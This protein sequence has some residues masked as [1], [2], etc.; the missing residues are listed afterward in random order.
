MIDKKPTRRYYCIIEDKGCDR[1]SVRKKRNIII[2]I[3]AC[4]L[5][6]MAV[7]YALLR[8]NLNISSTGTLTGVWKIYISDM[9]VKNTNGKATEVTHSFNAT[10]ANFEVDLYMP[11]DYVEYYITVT[12]D[13]NIDATLNQIIV[14]ATNSHED[15]KLSHT[16]EEG[17]VLNGGES[18][19]Y[20][21]KIEFDKNATKIP[22]IEEP[23]KYEIMLIYKT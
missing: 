14:N 17:E 18:K 3:L 23:V 11:G 6:L 8:Q 12:N 4:V 7:G 21:I 20:T 19:T 13:G 9:R 22:D 1:V 16:L 5:V 10:T 2:S 15:I